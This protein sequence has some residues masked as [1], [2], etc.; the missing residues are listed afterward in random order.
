MARSRTAIYVRLHHHQNGVAEVPC[1]S[2]PDVADLAGIGGFDHHDASSDAWACA[3]IANVAVRRRNDAGLNELL[4]QLN[5]VPGL[6]A[7]GLYDAAQ[8]EFES[9]HVPTEQTDGTIVNPGRPFF[10]RKVA[11]TGGLDS[12][13]RHEAQQAVLNAGGKPSTGPFQ[14]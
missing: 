11:F 9:R 12:M 4:S 6:L 1:Y 14:S 2:L 10:G 5:I 13:T 7:P 3:A 8:D